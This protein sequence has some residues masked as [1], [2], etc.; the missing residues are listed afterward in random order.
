VS[1]ISR[2]TGRHVRIT[3]ADNTGGQPHRQTAICP[4]VLQALR[5]NQRLLREIAFAYRMPRRPGTVNHPAAG[6]RW[7]AAD[8]PTI[9]CPADVD[10]LLGGEMSTLVQEQLRVVLLDTKNH[11]LACELVY[12]G[13]LHGIAI[14]AAEVLRPAVLVNAPSII[15][16]H[17][18]PSG[19]P[20]P[21]KEDVRTT[22][23]LMA[24][25]D[26][27]DIQVLDHII[28]GSE[29]RYVS[30]QECG[31]VRQRAEGAAAA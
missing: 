2:L 4:D 12:Q 15:V 8:P 10:T 16:V 31:L 17:N 23:R 18:H 24:A 13:T 11:V 1:H 14:R 21:S 19:D 25:G 7:V 22:E 9:C 27:V 3:Y 20:D 26:T 28:I 6:V 30:M 29:G 5:E